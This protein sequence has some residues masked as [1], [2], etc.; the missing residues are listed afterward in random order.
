MENKADT[1]R[2]NIN[3]LVEANIDLSQLFLRLKKFTNLDTA[4]LESEANLALW[5]A[6]TKFVERG[7]TGNF[8]NYAYIAVYHALID[9]AKKGKAHKRLPVVR[10]CEA[11]DIQAEDDLHIDLE[12]ALDFCS[13]LDPGSEERS[14][15]EFLI[16]NLTT[17][18][19]HNQHETGVE[20][21]KYAGS[22]KQYSQGKM[23]L[24]LAVL[25]A[26][27]AEYKAEQV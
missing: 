5:K 21:P 4:D 1:K 3:R 2:D 6:A 8:R 20:W 11:F 17:G 9:L 24:K 25:K 23:S 22:E 15:L 18:L 13:S 7:L 27:Y 14:L 12:E 19:A 16:S 10:L 26:K